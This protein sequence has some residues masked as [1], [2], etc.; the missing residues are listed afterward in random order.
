MGDKWGTQ[1]QVETPLWDGGAAQLLWGLDYVDEN[2]RAPFEIFDP[3]A[4]DTRNTLQKSG[5][6]H[7]CSSLRP[8]PVGTLC[9][10]TVGCQRSLAVERGAC[11]MSALVCG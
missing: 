10:T 7:L 3:V 5:R 8:V 1:V 11:V 2:N 6:A 4:F 9:P